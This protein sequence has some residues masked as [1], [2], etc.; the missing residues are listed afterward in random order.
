MNLSVLGSTGSIGR[1]TLELA[2][3]YD[4][5]NITGLAAFGNTELI[6]KQIHEF[7]PE[8]CCIYDEKKALELKA[9]LESEGS[10]VKVVSGMEGLIE[11]A[12]WE[13]TDTV[14]VSVVGMIGI[15][16]TIE[17][18]K[19]GKN[20]AQA[21]KEPIVCAGHIIMPLAKKY[22]ISFMPVDSEHSAIYQCLQGESANAIDKIWL[23]ASG[24]PFRG[25]HREELSNIRP[26]DALKHPSWNMGAKITIDSST[27]VNKGLEVIEAH[28]LF[29]VKA[30][31]IIVAVQPGSV[32]HSMV[33][34]EDGAI[35]AQLGS[36]DM[37]VPIAYALHKGHRLAYT[38]ER[39][40]GFKELCDIHFEEPDLETFK[41]LKL[42]IEAC[43]REGSLTTVY[44]AA[45]EECVAAFLAGRIGYLDIADGIEQA[46]AAHSFI[47]DP[48][49]EDIFEVEQEARGF[50]RKLYDLDK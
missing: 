41:G 29:N 18:I 44:N 5:I 14:L 17:A 6:Y 4:D 10:K 45:N 21:N 35:K 19:A 38:G 46:M 27:L 33:Q 48:S 25:R 7:E 20:I 36:P 39:K 32:V 2:E 1:Q 26:E 13:H 40:L 37:K 22:G 49:L 34:F 30:D 8:I 50:I 9:K 31:D 24:G 11:C 3:C 42:G 28:Y 43:R 12:V 16:P 47:A 15:R 23:T